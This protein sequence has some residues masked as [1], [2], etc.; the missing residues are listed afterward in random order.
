MKIKGLYGSSGGGVE[1]PKVVQICFNSVDKYAQDYQIIRLNDENVRDYIDLPEFVF[2]KRKNP[3][4][5]YAFFTDLLRLALL[6][7]YGGIWMD[8][9]ILLTAPLPE[10]ITELDFFMFQRDQH[11]PNKHLW[12]NFDGYFNWNKKHRINCLNSFIVGK[13]NNP[14]I[15]ICLNMLL[16][17]WKTQNH[18]P[19][20]F[21]F[22]IMFDVLC[23]EY[24]Y[25]IDLLLDDT[26]P[27]LLHKVIKRKF[28][29]QDYQHILNQ[30]SIHKL[31]YTKKHNPN[32]YFAHLKRA[33]L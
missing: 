14:I 22:Q 21:F 32:S 29:L 15:H 1:P 7:V 19:H 13:K 12:G 24:D 8:A 31:T 10:K 17:F 18:I 28:N 27:H 16:H 26:L 4:F 6:D 25:K 23:K 2:E 3:E 30:T 9:T 20:Y 33:F 11:S 5:K